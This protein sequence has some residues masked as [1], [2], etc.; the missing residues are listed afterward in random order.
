MYLSKFIM[1]FISRAGKNPFYPINGFV[2]LEKPGTVTRFLSEFEIWTINRVQIQI[3][4]GFDFKHSGS[5]CS[6][7]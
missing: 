2:L 4:V 6:D 5:S 1:C 3:L 7:F